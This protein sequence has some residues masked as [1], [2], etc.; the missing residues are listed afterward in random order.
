MLRTWRRT[1][2]LCADGRSK[3]NASLLRGEAKGVTILPLRSCLFFLARYVPHT[4]QMKRTIPTFPDGICIYARI[5][6]RV[7][8]REITLQALV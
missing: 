3:V 8:H 7:S 4:K 2:G 1:P 6:D 5:T